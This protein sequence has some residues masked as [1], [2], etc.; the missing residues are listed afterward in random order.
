M[1]KKSTARKQPA[2]APVY[3]AVGAAD[4][5]IEQLKKTL[6][7]VE[8]LADAIRT[9]LEERIAKANEE[10][11]DA[12]VKAGKVAHGAPEQVLNQG[13]TVASLASHAYTEMTQRGQRVVG[14]SVEEIREDKRVK[15]AAERAEA[16]VRAAA[17]VRGL[18]DKALGRDEDAAAVTVKGAVVEGE[19]AQTAPV[20]NV[21]AVAKDDKA[22]TPRPPRKRTAKRATTIEDVE[23]TPA[24]A[25]KRPSRASVAGKAT[26]M[27]S[28]TTAADLE[29]GT[30]ADTPAVTKAARAPR[31]PR[32]AKA[33]VPPATGGTSSAEVGA[34]VAQAATE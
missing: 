10:A 15:A 30:Q 16:T 24:K 28:A 32:T 18:A 6:A 8:T 29:E 12:A 4:L 3:A 13:L 2:V 1:S 25:T 7:Q 20:K 26:A 21:R 19:G 34:S 11:H 33:D 14:R 22:E 23:T 17:S 31:R 5:A 27:R 9:D